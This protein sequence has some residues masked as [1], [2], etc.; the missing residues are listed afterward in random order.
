MN[1]SVVTHH[2]TAWWRSH[3]A[4][5]RWIAGS[6]CRRRSG[7]GGKRVARATAPPGAA[8]VAQLH[9]DQE[10]VGQHDRDR[11]AMEARPQ[12]PLI[13]VP[14]HL[15]FGLFMGLFDGIPAVGLAGPLFHRGRGR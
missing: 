11:M 13:L 15:T 2:W 3:R 1:R 12:P 10:A 7:R 4:T 6:V 8:P 9:P 5:S 14:A